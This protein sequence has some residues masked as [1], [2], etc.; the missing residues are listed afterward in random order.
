MQEQNRDWD[1]LLGAI[2][3][4]TPSKS[5]DVLMNGWLLYQTLCCRIIARTGFY[6]S[7]GA[8]GF[9]DQL[10][11]SMALLWSNP[12]RT[13]SQILLHARRQFKEGDVQH[14]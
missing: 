3:I 9:R 12:A 7:S 14:W 10:Q 6:Q 1:K 8:L 4:K 13:R 2:A 5:F 11:D